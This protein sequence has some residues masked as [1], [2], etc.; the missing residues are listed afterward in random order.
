MKRGFVCVL[1]LTIVS[2]Q[3]FGIFQVPVQ[4]AWQDTAMEAFRNHNF[5]K[6]IEICQARKEKDLF[7]KL[8]LYFAHAEKYA[9]YKSKVDKA[10]RDSQE[11]ILRSSISIKDVDTIMLF[12]RETDK[13]ETIKASNQLLKVAF[14]NVNR[15]DELSQSLKF[16]NPEKY[17][18]ETYDL[19]MKTI[20]KFLINQ[21]K[22]VMK[23]GTIPSKERDFIVKSELIPRLVSLANLNSTAVNCLILIEDPAIEPLRETY[24]KGVEKA[25]IGI[26]KAVAKRLKKWPESTWFSAQPK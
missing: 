22:Y 7:G 14:D 13:P 3:L 5:D 1:F 6:A 15:I 25:L 16:L 19:A 24:G 4:A 23:G 21:R 18:S 9:L 12:A 2:I 17:T 8:I 10:A 11:K 20:K 26:E